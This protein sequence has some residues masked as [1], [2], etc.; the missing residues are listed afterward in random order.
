MEKRNK[1]IELM[2]YKNVEVVIED[3]KGQH[4]TKTGMIPKATI[5]IIFKDVV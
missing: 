2:K 3:R 5:R 1:E 4:A